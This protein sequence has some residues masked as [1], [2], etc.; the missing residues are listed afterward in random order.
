MERTKLIFKRIG[1]LLA[2]IAILSYTVFHI[3]SLFESELSTIVVGESTQETR[4]GFDGYIF[5]DEY[6]VTSSYGGA[7]DYVAYDGLKVAASETVAYVYEFGNSSDVSQ[8][9]EVI[10]R[11]IAILEGALSDKSTLSDLPSLNA[12]LRD[13]H[14]DMMKNIASGEL[15]GLRESIDELTSEMDKIVSVTGK[16][17]VIKT[18][19]S[20]LV[21]ERESIIAAGGE[22]QEIKSDRSG[23]FYSLVDGYEGVFTTEV[24]DKLSAEDFEELVTTEPSESAAIGKMTY[25]TEWR[26]VAM[27]SAE[28]A[29]H[30]AEGETYD[31]IFTGNGDVVFPLRLLK[32]SV[33]TDTENELLVFFCDRAPSGFSFERFQSVEAVV[34][35]VSGIT[36]PKSCVHKSGGEY[37]VYILNGSVVL[38]RRIMIIHDGRDHYTV[39]NGA[40]IDA[41]GGKAYLKANDVLI[42][43]GNNL[44]DGRIID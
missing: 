20:A 36:V 10:D 37:Y 34:E 18:T 17:E 7:V 5:R 30:F 16:E 2:C 43:D 25:D 6:P 32:R 14:T 33:D 12:S 8:R 15:R 21:S 23:Y 27:V 22:R 9:I 42:L 38:E 44:F 31:L 19:L 3:V 29:A 26:F 40:F 13:M 24:A 28:A 39:A 35:K 4:V 1:L 41:E 11:N